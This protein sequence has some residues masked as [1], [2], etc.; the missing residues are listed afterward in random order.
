MP[1]LLVRCVHCGLPHDLL[2]GTCPTTGKPVPLRRLQRPQTPSR[3]ASAQ[4]PAPVEKSPT[5]HPR[6]DPRDPIGTDIAGKYRLRRILGHGGMGTV[7]EAER[8]SIGGAVAIKVLHP[9]RIRDAKA[10]RRFHKEAR[11]AAAI[12]HPNICEIHDLGA[13]ADGSPYLVMERLIG[14]TLADRLAQEGRVAFDE[15]ADVLIQVLSALAVTHQKGIV[16]RDI[17]PANLFL[18]RRVGCAPLVKLLDFG[19]SKMTAVSASDRREDTRLTNPGIVMGTLGYMSLEQARGRRD[20]DARV[21]LYACGVILYETLT[22]RRPFPANNIRELLQLMKTMNPLPAGEV[23]S[24]L[25]AG[26]DAIIDRAMAR[27]RE[28]RYTTANDMQR[29]LQALRERSSATLAVAA[30]P[31]PAPS[32]LDIPIEFATETPQSGRTL[33]GVVDLT[34]REGDLDD[35]DTLVTP[36]EQAPPTT[37]SPKTPGE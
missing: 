5:P 12:G 6:R 27:N 32:S 3:F 20:L 22:G 1:S 28:N 37:R 2:E 24:G 8:L 23:V 25:P 18:S 30:V 36:V 14:E 35:H 15:A 16:H 31:E 26:V 9:D 21:D 10:V 7:Y 17:K 29:D 19:I 33:P 13:L 34:V 11:A 4:P